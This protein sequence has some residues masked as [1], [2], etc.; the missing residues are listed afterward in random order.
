MC[1]SFNISISLALLLSLFDAFI[2]IKKKRR[3]EE[4]RK[5]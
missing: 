4:K 5:E 3:K 2:I 1:D